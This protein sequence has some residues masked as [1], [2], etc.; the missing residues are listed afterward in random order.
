M[1]SIEITRVSGKM[2][3]SIPLDARLGQAARTIQ[4]G[5]RDASG[6]PAFEP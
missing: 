1:A 5:A 3:L 2:A 4:P 6:E